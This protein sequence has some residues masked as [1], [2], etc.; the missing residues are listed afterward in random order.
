[1]NLPLLQ[2][3]L[4]AGVVHE[5]L[6]LAKRYRIG[7]ATV[8]ACDIDLAI[9]TLEGSS[10]RPA[11]TASFPHGSSATGVKLYEIRDLLRRGAREIELVI[12]IPKLVSREFPYVQTELLQA[13]EA[14]H[15][16]GALL[17]VTLETGLLTDEMKMVACR[18]AERAEV[19]VVKTSTGFGPAATIEDVR[20]LRKNLPEEVQIEV[21]AIDTFERLSE[22]QA[23]G[24]TRFATSSPAALLDGL[25]APVT[26]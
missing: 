1:L 25:K 14:C 26:E 17:K 10:V 22:F 20:L 3:E 19:D 9:R 6:E 5:G 18:C 11:A 21:D 24:A 13:S 23:A 2:P 15:K 4:T 16:E 12:A 7:A 8:R